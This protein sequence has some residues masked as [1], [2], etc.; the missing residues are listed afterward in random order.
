MSGATLIVDELGELE[1]RDFVGVVLRGNREAVKHAGRL[2]GESVRV[3]SLADYEDMLHALVAVRARF[4]G[5][6]LD[7]DCSAVLD[8]VDDAIS[9]ARLEHKEAKP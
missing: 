7:P 9:R 4:Q 3:V 2:F 5:Y 8:R 1:G 6:R